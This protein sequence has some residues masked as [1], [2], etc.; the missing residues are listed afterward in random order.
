MTY[1]QSDGTFFAGCELWPEERR[2]RRPGRRAVVLDEQSVRLMRYLDARRLQEITYE[3]LITDIWGEQP[4][5]CMESGDRVSESQLERVHSALHKLRGHLGEKA[6]RPRFLFNLRDKGYRY[7]PGACSNLRAPMAPFIGREGALT[8]LLEH[9][10]SPRQRLV[11]LTGP[12]GVGKTALAQEAGRRWWARWARQPASEWGGLGGDVWFCDLSDARS[13]DELLLAVARALDVRALGR[14]PATQLEHVLE[15]RRPCLLI[16]DNFEQL[17]EH[18]PLIERWLGAAGCLRVLVTSRARLGLEGESCQILA[19]MSKAE[20]ARLF[21]QA[22]SRPL[23]ADGGGDLAALLEAL[24]GL[25]LAIKLAAGHAGAASPRQLTA[26]L[27]RRPEALLRARGAAASGRHS[28]MSA[29][30]ETSLELLSAAERGALSQ[31]LVFRGGFTLELA[32]QVLA[33]GGAE[34]ADC[35]EGLLERSLL[36]ADH[37]PEGARV[38]LY[39]VVERLLRARGEPDSALKHR[40]AAAVVALAEEARAEA[41]RGRWTETLEALRPELQNLMAVALE[42]E[43]PAQLRAQAALAVQTLAQAGLAT[44]A[45]HRQAM[46]IA[47]DLD[48]VEP[49]RSEVIM[50]L[51]HLRMLSG[52]LGDTEVL[53]QDCA[54]AVAAFEESTLRLRHLLLSADLAYF[55]GAAEAEALYLEALATAERSGDT[56]QTIAACGGMG[57][58]SLRRGEGA[59]ARDWAERAL[60]LARAAGDRIREAALLGNLAITL[61]AL[62]RD[63][64]DLAVAWRYNDQAIRIARDIGDRRTEANAMSTRANILRGLGLLERSLEADEASLAIQREVGN[65][66]YQAVVSANL[67]YSALLLGRL[68]KARA[69]LAEALRLHSD[70]G[71][72]YHAALA[73]GLLGMVAHR[74]GEHDV[75]EV[76]Y[77]ASVE[78]LDGAG[79]AAAAAQMRGRLLALLAGVGRLDEAAAVLE[80]IAP[81][82]DDHEKT[83]LFLGLLK[84]HLAYARSQAPEVPPEIAARE[85]ATA[86]ALL[87]EWLAHYPSTERGAFLVQIYP[88]PPPPGYTPPPPASPP[89]WLR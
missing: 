39:P 85:A 52:A 84:A 14:D 56:S 55:R 86:T 21:E 70:V 17:V 89:D 72:S 80:A 4:G 78:A 59:A 5:V 36:R 88:G 3:E 43:N 9:L 68:P 45:L 30:L 47:A 87:E 76:H 38:S 77:L 1:Q 46:E 65:R 13:I 34:T 40:H 32:E 54:E 20:G 37:T 75:A 51:A 2:L 49:Q 44:P 12:G 69:H 82:L 57:N 6:R 15:A 62:A 63:N 19:P 74:A 61:H 11:T 24:G 29:V 48:L 18:T 33:P 58:M 10:E 31:C 41:R 60:A 25:P 66:R 42:P 8:T 50:A 79:S 27:Q 7:V 53:L 64:Q 23:S 73:R 67:G 81:Q 83:R 28:S 35:V 71:D 22:A 26:R 16:L